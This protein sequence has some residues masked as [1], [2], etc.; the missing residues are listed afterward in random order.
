MRL[1]K[2]WFGLLVL[3]VAMAAMVVGAAC[4]GDDEATPVIIEKEVIVEREVIREVP[5]EVVVEKEVVI[6]VPKEIIV[7]KQVIKEV[8]VIR[9]VE[10]MAK[11][12]EITGE[13][14]RGGTLIYGSSSFSDSLHPHVTLS[15]STINRHSGMFENLIELE[16]SQASP[17]LKSATP[18]RGPIGRLAESWSLSDDKLTWTFNLRKG[19]KF[20]DGEPF[21]AQAVEMTFLSLIDEDNQYYNPEAAAVASFTT[22]FIESVNV[23]DDF[24]FQITLERPFYGFIG[25]MASVPCCAVISPKALSSMTPAELAVNPVGTGPFKFVEWT[26]GE[27]LI[28][29]RNDDYWDPERIPWVDQLIIVPIVDEAARTAALITGEIDIAEWLSPDNLQIIRNSTGYN[30]YARGVPA[31]YALQPNHREPPWN[32]QRVRRAASLCFDRQTLADDLMK[33]VHEPGAQIWGPSHVGKDPLGRKIT[34]NYDPDTAKQLLADAGYPDGFKTKMYSSTEGI[35]IPELVVNS[36]VVI[37]LREC[38]IEVELIN[39]EWITYLGYWSGGIQQGE[40]IGIFT[41]GMGPGDV[42]G[43]DQYLHSTAW[44]PEG[45]SIGWYA[46]SDVD[47]LIEKSWEATTD[48]EYL[49][50]ERQAHDVAL[51]DYAYIPVL[52]MF[53]TYGVSDRVGG[54]T[55]APGWM[56]KFHEAWI[57]YE[58]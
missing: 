39:L 4:G 45:W 38:G 6:E 54:W 31:F 57:E 50:L 7:E 30:G 25:K 19:I 8:E 41:M 29:E 12:P 26:R 53:L 5:K 11:G 34:D 40:D 27:K 24:T 49:K 22:S 43:F 21:N 35:G 14:K 28:M 56:V 55:G 1:K 23:V 13:P 16:R 32:D 47:A 52:D 3:A 37:Q 58:R 17:E 42:A 33:G 44:P 2:S 15:S 51:D 48:E 9:E 46:N 10:V 36:F 20:H 18:P